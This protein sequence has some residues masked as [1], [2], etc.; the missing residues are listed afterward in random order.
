MTSE[1]CWKMIYKPLLKDLKKSFQKHKFVGLYLR[2]QI[3]VNRFYIKQRVLC[4]L[5]IQHN[6]SILQNEL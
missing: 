4:I 6:K 3:R 1:K 2:F 5:Y